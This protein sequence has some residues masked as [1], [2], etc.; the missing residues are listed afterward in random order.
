MAR[1]ERDDRRD[2]DRAHRQPDPRRG[3]P[4]RRARPPRCVGDGE[5]RE[6]Q[7]AGRLRRGGDAGGQ[8]GQGEGAGGSGA[9]WGLAQGDGGEG[10]RRDPRGGQEK[11]GGQ[12]EQADPDLGDHGEDQGGDERP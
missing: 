5:R 11:V 6:E 2:D 1:L 4:S 9:A 12:R 3:P 8:A 10:K 7:E